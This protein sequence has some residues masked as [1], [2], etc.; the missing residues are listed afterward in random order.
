MTEI[1]ESVA[2]TFVTV[3]EVEDN[4]FVGVK[5]VYPNGKPFIWPVKYSAKIEGVDQYG[6]TNFESEAQYTMLAPGAKGEFNLQEETLDDDLAKTRKEIK[7]LLDQIITDEKEQ[8]ARYDAILEESGAMDRGLIMIGAFMTG[9]GDGAVGLVE[10][11]GDALETGGKAL[12]FGIQ[13]QSNVLEAAWDKYIEGDEKAFFEA[14]QDKNVKDFADTFGITPKEMA[15]SLAEAY[16]IMAFVMEDDEQQSMLMQF[17]K[18]YVLAQSKTEQASIVGSAVFDVILGAVLAATTGGAG[19]AAQITAK[20]RHASL[21]RPLAQKLVKFTKLGKNKKLPKKVDAKLDEITEVKVESA[22]K[23]KLEKNTVDNDKIKKEADKS[24]NK[25]ED[26]KQSE[27]KKSENNSKAES[28]T[29]SSATTKETDKPGTNKNSEP[30]PETKKTETGGE[31]ISLV[32]GEELLELTDFQFQGPVPLTWTRTYRSSNSDNIGLGHGWTHPLSAKLELDESEV[33]YFDAEGRIITFA[34]P[35]IGGNSVNTAENLSITRKSLTSFSLSATNGGDPMVRRFEAVSSNSTL[36]LHSIG[37]IYGNALTLHYANHRIATVEGQGETWRFSYNEQNNLSDIVWQTSTGKQKN[38]VAYQYDDNHDLVRAEDSVGNA[39]H[40]AFQ[41]HL[42]TKRTLKSGYSF[43]FQWD[44]QDSKARCVRN[45]GDAINGQPTYDYTFQWDRANKR[46]AMK[47]TRGGVAYSQ[48]NERGMPVYERDPEGAET[49]KEYDA[50]GNLIKVTDA[51]GQVTRFTYDA[52]AQLKNVVES[53]GIKRDFVRDSKGNLTQVIDP[54]GNSWKRKFNDRGQVISQINP[55]GDA[56]QYSYNQMG[57]INAITDP[58]GRTWNYLWDNLGKLIALKNPNAQQTRYT[59]SDFG[60]LTKITWPDGQATEYRY[61]H[62]GNCI[63]IKQPDGKVEQFSY[64]GLGL[65]T[66]HQD[67]A[68]RRTQYQYNGLSQVIRRIDPNGQTLD[69]G[70]DGERNLVGLSNEKGEQYTLKYDLNE[71]LIQEKGFDGRIQRYQYNAAGHLVSSEDYSPDGRTLVNQVVYARDSEGR[72]LKQIDGRKNE[73]L[74]EFKYDIVGRLTAAKNP[75]RSLKW[76]YDNVG[77]VVEDWQDSNVIKHA[78]D[79]A[80][81]RHQTIL[82]NG[83]NIQYHFDNIGAFTGLDFNGQNVAS[84][85]R[86]AMGRELQR[87]LSNALSSEQRYDPQGRLVAQR[88]GKTEGDKPFKA[89]SQRQFH[90]NQ[91]GQLAQID[92]QIRGST[93]YHYDALDRLTKVEGPNPESFVHDPAGNILSTQSLATESKDSPQNDSAAPTQTPAQVSGNRLAFFGDVHYQYDHLGNRVGQARGKNQSLKTT[94]RYNALN[95]LTDVMHNNVHTQ[96]TYDPLGRRIGKRNAQ[97]HTEFLWLDDVL[98]SEKELTPENELKEEKIYLFEPG[99]FKPMAF[100]Q[101]QEVYH[102][103]LDHLGTPQEITNSQ[104][105]IVW[106]VS[107]KAYGNL[108]VAYRN[109]VENNLR[110][111]GQYFD[112]ETGLH[113]NRFRYYDPGCGRFITLDPV[114]LNGGLNAYSYAPNPIGWT[115]PLGLTCKESTL[116]ERGTKPGPGERSLSKTEYKDMMSRTRNKG[117]EFQADLDRRLDQEGFVYRATS[118][119]NVEFYKEAGHVNRDA[120]MTFDDVGMDPKVNMDKSQ[121][122]DHWGEPDVLLKIPKSEI[123]DARVPRPF[124]GTL[125]KGWEPVTEA[126]PAAGSGGNSQFLGK[127]KSWD[128]SW[129]TPLDKSGPKK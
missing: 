87:N 29:S 105:E 125:E 76:K 43:Y 40:Y 28:K 78:Y 57:Y 91:F 15:R 64:N 97:S 116:H 52:A 58:L 73:T 66:N 35:S 61:D 121:V 69:Y 114:G 98:L 22:A 4:H 75:F 31:P 110:F 65:L 26:K 122:F 63:A 119:R 59:Y 106:A 47:D 53:S 10:F 55:N 45:W 93:K 6:C 60:E 16:E 127:T 107:F 92:D 102:Y 18:D 83:E 20:V 99:T 85:Q 36:H 30:T 32:T 79:T 44:A 81:Q 8:K 17:A 19:N 103:H 89:V 100:V 96:Y 38:L 49:R 71:R 56:I 13:S 82:P 27:T 50:L 9:V 33:K 62:N 86:D 67:S 5:L 117:P 7:A 113:Y 70:Y 128:D 80:G 84:I 24:K 77:R 118:S 123:V 88:T 21:F 101:E 126:Y 39:E 48:F 94:Y 72:L 2:P 46:V 3:D 11:V 129:V 51:L 14:V 42:I 54:L 23:Q 41:N 34:T 108:A 90:Y 109:Q 25:D 37:D 12:W 1:G 115:D 68:G 95:Q 112:E 120:Y 74:N 104:G 111:Q 124:G